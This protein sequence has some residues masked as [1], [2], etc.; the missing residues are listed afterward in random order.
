VH[1]VE[2]H[3]RHAR[4]L[5]IGLDARQEDALGHDQMRVRADRLL[6]RRVR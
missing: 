2:Q 6:S 5:R 1:F 4:K 3:G